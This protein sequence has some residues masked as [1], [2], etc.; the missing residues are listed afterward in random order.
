MNAIFTPTRRKLSADEFERLGR[1]GILGEDARVELIEGEMIEMAPIGSRHAFVVNSLSMHF[2]RTVGTS[3]LVSTQN[4]LRLA[5]DTEPQPDLML[6]QP[7]PDR[8]RDALPRPQD[9]LLLIEVA[10]TTLAYDRGI[11]LP[12]YAT[13]GVREVWL[14]DLDATRVEIHLAPA[15]AAYR[16]SLERGPADTL[17]PEALP[18]LTL[19]LQHVI[20]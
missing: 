10:N 20:G 2:A 9:V 18:A 19:Q 13:H 15:G 5:E 6:L 7:R 4:P 8:Y 17:S 16:R 3:A 1:A 14:L 12:L 11:K